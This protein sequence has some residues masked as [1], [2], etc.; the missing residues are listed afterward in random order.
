MITN[1]LNFAVSAS[2]TGDWRLLYQRVASER[3]LD[4]RFRLR[5]DKNQQHRSYGSIPPTR[6]IHHISSFSSSELYPGRLD[7]LEPVSSTVCR[8]LSPAHTRVHFAF[9]GYQ[10]KTVAID[11][12]AQGHESTVTPSHQTNLLSSQDRC[13]AA[14]AHRLSFVAG[15]SFLAQG[16]RIAGRSARAGRH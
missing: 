13:P 11:R 16:R 2:L 3:P 14:I 12:L 1:T 15:A 7:R 10:S 6:T 8:Y 4:D 5:I 9:S